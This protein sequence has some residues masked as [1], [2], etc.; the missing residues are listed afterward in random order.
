MQVPMFSIIVAVLNGQNTLRRCVGSI[1]DQSEERVELFVIDGGST[2]GTLELLR[3]VD[4]PRMIVS[5]EPDR[6][7]CDA[8]NKGLLAAGGEWICFLGADDCLWERDTLSKA[9]A[10]LTS[11]GPDVKVAYGSVVVKT[12]RGDPL[13]RYGEPWEIAGPR[14][15]QIMSIPH[16]A[17]FHRASLFRDRG[18]FDLDFKIAGDYE[19]LLRELKDRPAVY[20]P[21]LIVVGMGYGGLS[22]NPEN[23][24]RCLLEIRRAQLKNGVRGPRLLWLYTASKAVV[25]IVVF[26]LLGRRIGGW[27]IDLGRL[28]T[29]KDR[30]WTRTL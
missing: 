18:N 2:D 23:A 25:R 10:A 17:T 14:F 22:S 27:L 19:L 1:L 7:I 9:S 15:R 3:S 5:S 13:G 6:G 12:D 24:L 28:A 30:V 29:G 4:D 20:L 21:D 26:R 16:Q 11:V 8:W